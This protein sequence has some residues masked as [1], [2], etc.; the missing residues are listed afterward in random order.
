MR[1]K[2]SVFC[3][4]VIEAGWLLTLIVAPL[5]FNVYSSR[6]FEPDKLSIVRSIALV[7]SAAWLIKVLDVYTWGRRPSDAHRKAPQEAPGPSLWQRI[8]ST[9]LVLPT[10]LLVGAYLLSTLL[11]IAPR[12]S[13]W[14]SYVRLQGTYTTFS[15]V[16]I[17]FLMLNTMRRQDQVDRLTTTIILTSLPISLYGILQHYGLDSLPN[18]TADSLEGSRAALRR[19]FRAASMAMVVVSSSRPGTAFSSR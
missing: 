12:I 18:Q 15:Y 5:F 16:I 11:S 3:E 8:S 10:I 9:P 6:V 1:T 19:A 14:G 7:M 4:K 13:L 2:L 17:F